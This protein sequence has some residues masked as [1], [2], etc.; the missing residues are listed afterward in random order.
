MTLPCTV[1]TCD[2]PRRGLGL[3]MFHYTRHRT[4]I[5]LEAPRPRSK[6]AK[7]PDEAVRHI[8]AHTFKPGDAKRFANMYGVAASVI[9]HVL[10]GRIYK[11]IT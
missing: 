6:Q 1:A 3:C 11:D 8:R 7:L 5:P 2:R 4:G 9:S 10:T